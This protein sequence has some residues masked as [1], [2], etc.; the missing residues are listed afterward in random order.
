LLGEDESTEVVADTNA[1]LNRALR[2][3]LAHLHRYESELSLLDDTV[4]DIC[5]YHLEF[6]HHFLASKESHVYG[7]LTKGFEQIA[8]QVTSIMHFRNEMQHKADNVLALVSFFLLIRAQDS[9]DRT[10]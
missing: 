2:C 6:F 8:S 1:V 10:S 4:R 5:S 9:C 3:I 7:T